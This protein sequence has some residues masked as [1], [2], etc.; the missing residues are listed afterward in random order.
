MQQTSNKTH[1]SLNNIY[2]YFQFSPLWLTVKFVQ[3][4]CFRPPTM[5]QSCQQSS[6]QS[7]QTFSI[8]ST[9]KWQKINFT[10]FT[11]YYRSLCQ[12][13]LIS[14]EMSI[15]LFHF[16]TNPWHELFWPRGYPPHQFCTF[17]SGHNFLCPVKWLIIGFLQPGAWF[18]LRKVGCEFSNFDTNDTINIS[19]EIGDM[20]F[21]RD[22]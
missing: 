15:Q 12:T 10:S 21:L 17:W 5:C 2:M 14:K 20:T 7:F 6:K 18:L 16:E 11:N 4:F 3:K 8:F 1:F 9:R 19:I 22:S 13:L